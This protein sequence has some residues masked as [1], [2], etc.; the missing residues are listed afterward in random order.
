EAVAVTK[1][2]AEV[3]KKEANAKRDTKLLKRSRGLEAKAVKLEKESQI[4]SEKAGIAESKAQ[5]ALEQIAAKEARLES[6]QK[7]L[8]SLQKEK[9]E[10]TPLIK[11]IAD[12]SIILLIALITLL[13]LR[14]CLKI[15]INRLTKKSTNIG[16]EA[17]L[18][19]KTFTRM[20]GWL[21]VVLIIIYASFFILETFGVSVTPLIAGAGIVGIAFGFGGQY[22]IRDIISGFFILIEDQYRIDDVVKIGEYSGLVEDINLRITTLRD[23]ESRVIIIP[24]GE[25]K[26]VINYTKEYSHALFDMRIAYKENVDQVIDIIKGIGKEMREDK[27][28]GNFILEDLEMFGVDDFLDSAVIIKFRIKTLPMKQWEVSR[29]FKRRMKNRFDSLGIKI[30]FPHRTIYWGNNKDGG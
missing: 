4:Y 17:A 1:Q 26:A 14:F 24:N 8:E 18:R 22:L 21:G 30:P 6:L 16:R 3:L 10:K 29:E 19:I 27:Y 7:A 23:L 13:A 9:A 20:F 11:K 25:I 12:G 15:F 28:Y 2:E 5:I